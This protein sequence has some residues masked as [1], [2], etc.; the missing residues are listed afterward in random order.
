MDVEGVLA[1][2]MRLAVPELA[3][4]S[5]AYLADPEGP[6]GSGRTLCVAHRDPEKVALVR[7]LEQRYPR[8][9]EAPGGIA[10]TLR[11]GR[12]QVYPAIPAEAVEAGARDA[13]HLALLQALAPRALLIVALR[14]RGRVLGALALMQAESGRSFGPGSIQLVEELARRASLSL[15]NALLYREAREAQARAEQLQ[16]ITAALAGASR[17]VEVAEAIIE[18]GLRAVGATRGSVS[19]LEGDSFEVLRTFGYDPLTVQTFLRAPLTSMPPAAEA[20]RQRSALWWRS[21]EEY[22][23]AYPELAGWARNHGPGARAVLPL[24]VE[25]RVIG[26]I[27]LTWELPRSVSAVERAHIESMVHQCAQALER[28]RL[29]D[30]LS[31]SERRL[32]ALAESMPQIVWVTDAAGRVEYF[33]RPWYALTGR[34]E[35]ESLGDAWAEALHAEDRPRV[36]EAWKAAVRTHS[37]YEQ[38][39][40]CRSTDG[41]WRWM[42]SRARPERSPSGELLRWYGTSTD[43]TERKLAEEFQEQLI[44]IVGHDV[45]SPLSAITMSARQLEA[46]VAEP[47]ARHVVERV[48]RGAWRIEQVIRLLLDFTRARLGNGI[49]LVRR[50]AEVCDL[51]ARVADEFRAA[52][53]SRVVQVR[54]SAPLHAQ[55]DGERLFQVLA[56]LVENG[57]KYGRADA[58]VT[59]TARAEAGDL[60]LEVH[61]EGEPLPAAL[62]PRLFQ[63]FSRGA[64]TEETVKVSLGLGLFIVREIV[65]AHEGSVQVRSSAEAGTTFTV[66]LPGA[67]RPG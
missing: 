51:L 38:E 52:Q 58:P 27:W 48:Q 56:N 19:L 53:P 21:F 59:A 42:L 55:V 14:A 66:R 39:F 15:D 44:G 57:L 2:V 29:H 34:S 64:Q 6:P 60:V 12:T 13:E 24:R 23:A 61:N 62:L 37:P 36:I 50:D 32:R 30:A 4:Y 47:R 33:N 20:A 16:A 28:T 43:I 63:P 41:S 7:A 9:P 31:E 3:D 17:S 35:E 54:C 25:Q 18:V 65:R 49:P 67:L 26:F 1:E 11:T 8:G 40:R 46:L 22:A 45:R 5:G 10:E